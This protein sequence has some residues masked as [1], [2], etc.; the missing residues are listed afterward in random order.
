MALLAIHS[1]IYVLA[2]IEINKGSQ[3][4]DTHPFNG[5]ILFDTF[6]QLHNFGGILLDLVMAVHADLRG[7]DT[8][9]FTSLRGKVAVSTIDLVLPRMY[10]VRERNGLVGLVPLGIAY[11][12]R[13]HN[14]CLNEEA[15][16]GQNQQYCNDLLHERTLLALKSFILYE[17][18]SYPS[19]KS[20]PAT[21]ATR[22]KRVALRSA[23][24]G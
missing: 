22:K 6:S 13:L 23:P 19:S 14:D 1:S 4:V 21:I 12:L 20:P 18:S 17:S 9:D 10:F 24:I 8:S 2:V 11:L 3:F 16:H 15:R 5:L 7:R